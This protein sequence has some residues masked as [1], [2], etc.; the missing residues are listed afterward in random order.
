MMRVQREEEDSAGN[1]GGAAERGWTVTLSL[2]AGELGLVHVGVG[3]R[4]G[5]VSV[6]LSA[7]SAEGAEQLG[8]WLPELKASLELAEF[9]PG[10]L[11]AAQLQP[12]DRETAAP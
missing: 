1:G 9:Q 4:G 10:E 11:L 8:S 5:S 7:A 3:L 12:A 6:R 2:D